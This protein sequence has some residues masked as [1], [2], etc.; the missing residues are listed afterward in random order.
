MSAN[1]IAGELNKRGVATPTGSPWSAKTVSRGA[2]ALGG[3]V[4]KLT[5]CA[6]CGST[7]DPQ[8]H[9]LVTRDKGGSNRFGRKRAGYDWGAD[10]WRWGL[11]VGTGT[12]TRRWDLGLNIWHWDWD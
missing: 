2:A 5:F 3:S 11:Q 12:D 6:A 4:M 8:H 7:D 1:A 10:I 9:H